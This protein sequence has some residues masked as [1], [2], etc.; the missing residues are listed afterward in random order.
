MERKFAVVMDQ[1]SSSSRALLMDNSGKIYCRSQNK[2]SPDYPSP[3]RAEYDAEKL[4]QSQYASLKEVLNALPS[5]AGMP[6]LGIASQRST[7]ILWNG[8]NGQPLCPAMS[9]QDGRAANIINNIP[10]TQTNIHS[11]TGLYKTPYYSA[12]K[13]AWAIENIASVRAA[14]ENGTLRAGPVPTYILWRLSG[15]KIFSCD[16]SLAQRMLLMNIRKATWEEKLLNTFRIKKQCLPNI[17][18]TSGLFGQILAECR[19]FQAMSMIGDQQ[20][21]MSG[22]GIEKEGEGAINYGTGAFLLVHTGK[23]PLKIKGLIDTFGWKRQNEKN[24]AYFSEVL[25]NSAG[26]MLEWLSKSLGFFESMENADSLCRMSKQRIFCLPVIGG[27]A[28]PY[29]DF[30][31][32]TC[33]AGLTAASSR[34]DLVR[35]AIEGIAFMIADGLELIRAKGIKVNELKASGGLSKM[36]YLMQFQADITG[37]RICVTEEQEA[38]ALGAGKE[39]FVGAG[40]ETNFIKPKIKTFLPRLSDE[41]RQRLLLQWRDFVRHCRSGNRIISATPHY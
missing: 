35:A 30:D 34:A 24:A 11:I 4:Y 10:L 1:G 13:I 26:S 39:A 8:N 20:A 17:C 33:F 9:W 15:G 38:T 23:R 31:V 12:S 16:P 14:A 32:R 5:E 2:I 21:A 18:P 36:S 22:L 27:L 41:E 19:N 7:I 3:G 37:T 29:W 6:I 25:V 40:I 28:A